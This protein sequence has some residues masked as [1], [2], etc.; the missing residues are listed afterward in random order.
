MITYYV[1]GNR[2]DDERNECLGVTEACSTIKAALSFTEIVQGL[3][4]SV[5]IIA[6]DL[7]DIVDLVMA[8]T[9]KNCNHSN[10]VLRNTL[11]SG[12]FVIQNGR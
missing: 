4:Y 3:Q 10:E 12:K 11:F 7:A 5:W 1:N 6:N 2:G 9:G 8:V